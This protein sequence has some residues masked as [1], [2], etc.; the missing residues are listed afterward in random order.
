M[1][2]K[3]FK[4]LMEIKILCKILDLSSLDQKP[5]SKVQDMWITYLQMPTNSLLQT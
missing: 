3:C 5:R 4:V 1:L 2:Q